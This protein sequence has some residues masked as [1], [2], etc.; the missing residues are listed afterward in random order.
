MARIVV[1]K[2]RLPYPP[3]TGTDVVTYNL[4]R[5]LARRHDVTLVALIESEGQRAYAQ[6]FADIGVHLTPVLMP[7]KKSSWHRAVYKFLYAGAAWLSASPLDLWYFNP[8]IFRR[9]V[10]EAARQ[11]DLVQFEYWYLYPSGDAV[12]ATKKILL[13]HDAEFNANRRLVAVTKNPIF[14]L[15]HYMTYLR[16]RGLEL[17][18]CRKFDA[19][20]CLSPADAEA[21][22][23]YTARP[24]HVVFPIVDLPPSKDLCRGFESHTLIYF[25]GTGRAANR[26]GLE[27]FLKDI[28]PRVKEAVGAT[29]FVIYG[30]RPRRR[31]RRLAARDTSVSF[32]PAV[33]DIS[34]RL[35]GAAV[36]V[37]PLWVGAGIKI[38]VL[39]ALAHG[40]PVV[41]TPVGAEGI[42][43]R[44]DA[45]I[46]IADADADFAL[47]VTSLLTD[48]ERWRA[49]AAGGR[50]YAE[51]ELA[52]A[53]RDEQVAAFYA[54]LAH[55]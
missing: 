19:V 29:R 41:T 54:E 16:R 22:A 36:A 31:L 5:A 23:P 40:L 52:P 49:L 55:P 48:R 11:A 30:E 9:A 7:N 6:A 32:E 12:Q 39:T 42:G 47:A 37:V 28:Y 46:L 44:A 13:K 2:H 33:A 14:K 21:I 18:A 27:V 17:A 15:I 20:L 34:P 38:K 8:P 25:G 45:E 43:A 1:A 51:R 53:A 10:A 35:A 26:H 4:L 50:R 3:T 24:P